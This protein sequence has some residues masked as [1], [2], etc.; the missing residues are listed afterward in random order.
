[1][2]VQL[3]M[4][5]D[6][7]YQGYWMMGAFN[8]GSLKETLMADEEEEEDSSSL[9]R[10]KRSR[11]IH[12]SA[13]T[14]KA[15]HLMEFHGAVESLEIAVAN[16]TEFVVILSG[17]DRMV[18]RP[19]DTYL[20]IDNFVFG[21]HSEKKMILSFLLQ[22]SPAAAVPTV[23]PIIG[24]FEVGK[25]TLVLT[26]EE[27]GYLFKALAFGSANPG[28]HPQLVQ[29]ADRFARELQSR[30]SILAANLFADVMRANLNVHFWL[31]ILSRC[32]RLV[33]RNLAMFGEHPKLRLEKGL[34]IDVT[35][36]VLCLASPLQFIWNSS[37]NVLA[38]ELPQ[39]TFTELLVD[40]KPKMQA[41][42]VRFESRIPPYTTFDHILSRYAQDTPQLGAKRRIVP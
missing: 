12:G 11:I 36:M 39:V 25:K 29:I 41:T 31:S 6:A 42:V 27:F 16:I 23:L 14:H 1:M 5:A 24:G 9:F 26:Y 2:L 40:L 10:L 7:M 33:D 20:Y 21:R 19:Y 13:R 37:N 8:Y 15:R 22:D 35:D 18:C 3:K 38:K 4:L 28:E 32:R 34:P 17:C 30:W